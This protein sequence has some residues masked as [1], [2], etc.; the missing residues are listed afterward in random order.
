VRVREAPLEALAE[1]VD[2]R[3]LPVRRDIGALVGLLG[4]VLGSVA[5]PAILPPPGRGDPPPS[6]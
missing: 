2:A 4:G 1:A 6:G 5:H 3:M